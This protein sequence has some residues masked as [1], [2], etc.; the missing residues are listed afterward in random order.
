MELSHYLLEHLVLSEKF[1][2]LGDTFEDETEFDIIF[3]S[4]K[5][6]RNNYVDCLEIEKLIRQSELHDNTGDKNEQM[7]VEWFCFER[8]ACRA[9]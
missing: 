6:L 7:E 9:G 3:C 5:Y 1:R 8:E 4:G 2:Q